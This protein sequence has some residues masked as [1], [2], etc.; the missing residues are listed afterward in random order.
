HRADDF[1]RVE[2]PAAI[3]LPAA[4][5]AFDREARPGTLD[6]GRYRMPYFVWGAGPPLVF[7][8]G[9]ADL[10]KSFVPVM[11]ALRR[12]FTCVGYEL[13]AGGP[14]GARL[15]AYRHRH[16]VADLIALLD[17]LR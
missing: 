9:L 5:A 7:I 14:D 1:V 4:L 11:A 16:L 10:A 13:P 12:D 8:H 2:T 15:G 6:T 3:P 17:H